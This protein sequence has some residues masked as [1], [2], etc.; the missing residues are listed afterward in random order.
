[1][2][3]ILYTC[4]EKVVVVFVKN[5]FLSA[6]LLTRST[7]PTVLLDSP[8]LGCAI[9]C[10]KRVLAARRRLLALGPKVPRNALR[11][12]QRSAA[13]REW[14]GAWGTQFVQAFGILQQAIAQ[15][16]TRQG[17]RRQQAPA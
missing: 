5:H 11:R 8:W 13:Q 10:V 6:K 2:I 4:D 3:I 17:A 1:V 14:R 9:I 12:E 7:C 16:A 15:A